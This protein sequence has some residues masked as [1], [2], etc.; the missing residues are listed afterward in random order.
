MGKTKE[1]WV[2]VQVLWNVVHLASVKHDTAKKN[3]KI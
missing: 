1:D 2:Q 3:L